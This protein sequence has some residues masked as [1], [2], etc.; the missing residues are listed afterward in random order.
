M[1]AL[2]PFY[3][4]RMAGRILGKGDI[5][6]FVEKAQ[7][8]IDVKE[9]EKLEEKLKKNNLKKNLKRINLISMIFFLS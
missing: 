6:S 2:E 3:P 7:E 4:D 5:V 1:E 8:E 9:A